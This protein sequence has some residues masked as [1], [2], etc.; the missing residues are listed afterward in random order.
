[1]KK[2]DKLVNKIKRLLKRMSCPRWLHHYGPK[3]YEFYQH[4]VALL[5]K[6]C[7]KLSFRRVSKL[8]NLLG[9]QVPTY[10]ALCRMRKRIPFWMWK[11]ILQLTANFDS[12]LVA[13]DSTGLSRT[14][15]SFHY[16]KRIDR[17]KPVKSYIKLSSFFDTRRKKF[18]A[19]R[20]RA[21]PRHDTK[22]VS[23]LLKQRSNMK[24]LLGDSSY[25]A[26]WVH[27]KAHELG[28]ITVMKPKKK[29]KKGFY[30]KKQMKHYSERT[31]HR[32][33]MIESGF[34]S[35]KRKYGGYTL[36]R[37]WKAIRTEAY[38]RAISHNLRL[39]SIEI[40]N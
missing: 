28:I 39:S 34:G 16:I 31:Y 32:R 11:N 4:I 20:I 38:L 12:H 9:I 26:E 25:D 8:L 24:K 33:S 21:K 35:L 18:L 15:P 30:R 5:L 7:F 17:K 3:T 6:E 23:Y 36:A 13:V 22:D 14:N 2:E 1:M 37:D 40:F 27:E 29:V 10:S 19:L